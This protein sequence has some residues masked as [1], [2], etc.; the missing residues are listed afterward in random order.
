MYELVRELFP[1]CRSI[2]GN[3]VRETLEIIK[4]HIPIKIHEVP[5]GTKVFDWIIPKEWNIKDAYVKNS[6]GEKIIDF[7]KSNLHIL[8]YSSPINKKVTLSELKE[9]L[10]TLPEHP[11]WIPYRTSYYKENWGFCIPHEQFKKLTEDE[12]EVVISS[13]LDKGH[14]TYG[15][16]LL[17]GESQNEILFS[18]YICHPSM[19]NDNL[20]GVSLLTFLAKYLLNK[21]LKF[22]YR[23]LFIPETI[24][25]ITWLSINEKKIDRIKGGLVATC[26][27]DSG[28]IT[29]KKTRDGNSM[30]DKIVENILKESGE[31]YEI[32]DFFPAGSDERQFSSPGFNLPIGS[33]TRTLYGKFPEYHTSA[34]NLDFVH[35]KNFQ[36][37]FEKYLSVIFELEEHFGGSSLSKSTQKHTKKTELMFKNIYP[38]CEPNLGKRGLYD[39]IGAK[40]DGMKDKMPIFWVLNF[41]DGENSLLD[42][43]QR[44]KIE[45][46][47]I[48]LAAKRLVESGLIQPI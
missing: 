32:I 47:D 48:K 26:L 22:S 4:K 9:H 30:I 33:I 45:L 3:G 5:S 39:M 20:S 15:E 42:I 35:P 7:K 38:K 41:S 24:G 44:S 16:L 12:Y 46:S 23:F 43:S 18:C 19:C 17:R 29:Y 6:K 25:A 14:L 13:T 27:G 34:D 8:N 2:T 28:H 37:T 1:I 36:S 21:K 40:K 31:K 10:Y 11:N